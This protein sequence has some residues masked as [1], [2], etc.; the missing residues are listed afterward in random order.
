VALEEY[1]RK[2]NPERTTEPFGAAAALS[3]AGSRGALFVVQKHAARQLH[4]DLRLEMEGVLRSWAVPKGP[5]MQAGEKRLAVM[6]EDHP[7]EYADFEGVISPGNYGAG[8]AIVWDRGQYQVIDPPGADPAEA[9]RNG[10]LDIELYGQKL[11]G[12][13]TMVRTRPRGSGRA[14]Q[15]EQWL[16]IKKRDAFATQEDITKTHPRSVLS[17]FTIEDLRDAPA[18]EGK[19]VA[20]LKGT[21]AAPIHREFDVRQFPLSL[22]KLVNEPFDDDQWL[23]EIKYDGVRAL[24]I[25][26]HEIA[27]LFARS[28]TEITETYP[29]ITFALSSLPFQ[30][31]VMDGEIIAEGADGRPNFQLLQRRMHVRDRLSALRLSGSVPVRYFVFDL[32]AFDNF[33]LRALPLE[34][35]KQFLARVVKGEGPVR[36]CE[37]TIG[38]GRAFFDA[39]AKSGLEGIMAKRRSSPYRGARTGDWLKIKCPTTRRFVI[40]G[41]TAARGSRAQLGALLLGLRES[42]GRLRFVGKVGS[43][44]SEQVLSDLHRVLSGRAQACSPF[45]RPRRNERQIPGKAHYCDPTLVCEVRFAEVTEDGSIR[46]PVFVRLVP[47]ADPGECTWETTFAPV[48]EPAT[49]ARPNSHPGDGADGSGD[50][51]SPVTRADKIFWPRD[52]YTKGDFIRYYESIARYMLP[53]LRDRPV[54]VE[55]FPDGIEGKSFVQKEAPDFAPKWIRAEKIADDSGTEKKCLVIESRR[56]LAW[57]ANLGAIPIHI[58][59]SRIRHLVRPDWLLF[60]LDP[61]G[62]TTAMAVE[63]A[64]EVIDILGQLGLRSAVKTSG[65]AGLHVC[66]GLEPRYTYDQARN[67]CE[68]VA[69]VIAARMP[70]LATTDRPIASRKGRVY[71]DCLQLGYGRT[72]AAPFTVRPQPGAP[73]STPIRASELRKGLDPARFNI[74]TVPIRMKRQGA[75]PYLGALQDKQNL[76]SALPKLET[77]LRSEALLR[78]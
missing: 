30:R 41:Y 35:R 13:F 66:V 40:G 14:E 49:A 54:M 20:D 71:I 62:S 27:R 43:G 56:A 2:R 47:D 58:W 16:L 68:L 52:G 11:R 25:R 67:F 65:Q 29:E 37:H 61:K 45:R 72:I 31:F 24:T 7:L 69:R 36:Y 55:R 76:E 48:P 53:Y 42:D 73:V 32:L 63:V 26:D 46:H 22:G 23:F 44:F 19:L 38:H 34:T 50:Q 6:V 59:S 77:L 8:T 57:I 3:G 10:K 60:D 12:A 51:P 39:V 28:R 21:G 18:L 78:E 4:Y 15:R 64:R 75:D 74:K 33:D 17:G 5:A 9:V 1:R 70:D